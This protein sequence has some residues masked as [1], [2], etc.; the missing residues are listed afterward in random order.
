MGVDIVAH[1]LT[2]YVSGHS[3]MLAGAIVTTQEITSKIFASG[4]M[5]QG[6]VLSPFAAYFSLRGLRT[7][8]IRLKE[9]EKNPLAIA[10]YLQEHPKV[11]RVY[12]PALNP[13]EEKYFGTQLTGY[14]GV[15]SFVL[16][17]QRCVSVKGM[18]DRLKHF[19]RGLSWDGFESMVLA[20]YLCKGNETCPCDQEIQP[21]KHMMRVS[22]GLEP[23]ELLIQD[24]E[25]AL[26]F[27]QKNNLFRKTGSMIYTV[28]L[29]PAIDYHIWLPQ[30]PA[31]GK[32][33]MN[34]TLFTPGGK[35]IN[36]SVVLKNLGHFSTSFGFFGGFTGIYLQESLHALDIKADF[37][38]IDAPSR[39]NVKMHWPQGELEIPGSSPQ[40]PKEIWQQFLEKLQGL[41][42]GDILVLSGSIPSSLPAETYAQ[43]CDFLDKD[44]RIF[45]DASGPD[46]QHAIKKKAL[47]H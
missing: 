43:L 3:D 5:L 7:L 11:K 39:I 18:I 45:V 13:D 33:S 29:N 44:V 31:E 19:R 27:V 24:L 40:I 30:A 8:P 28:T 35:G 42:K 6:A 21:Y 37:L 22:I 32:L 38:M 46:L 25:K 23:L 4:Y 26:E 2:K 20:P 16:D 10:K 9:H 34:K 47:C 17:T 1:S 14:A 36:V 15:F 41:T 12:H